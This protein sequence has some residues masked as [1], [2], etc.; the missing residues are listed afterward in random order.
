MVYYEFNPLEPDVNNREEKLTPTT[1]STA[2]HPAKGDYTIRDTECPGLGL[3][4]SPGAKTWIIRKKLR[5]QSYRHTLGHYPAMTLDQARRQARI[6]IGIFTEGRHPT[7]IRESRADETNRQWL[8]N[9]FTVADMWKEWVEQPNKLFADSTRDDFKLVVK[10]LSV[11]PIWHIPFAKLTDET[12]VDAFNRQSVSTDRRATNG[13]RTT[14][15]LIFRY[16]GTAAKHTI[17]KKFKDHRANPIITAMEGKWHETK[18]RTRTVIGKKD[19]LALWWGAVDELRS[20]SESGDGR[21]RS[22]AIIADLLVLLLFWGG[23]KTETLTL[24]WADVNFED[25]FVVFRLPKNGQAHFFPLAPYA[26]TVLRRIQ[27]RQWARK[28]ETEWVFASTRRGNNGGEL[29]HIK[30]PKTSIQKVVEKSGI[31]FSP[32]DMRR[33]FGN[34]IAG[35]D[36]G[37]DT[38]YVKMAM[39]HSVKS[40]VTANHYLI[41]IDRLRPIYEKMEQFALRKSGMVAEAPVELDEEELRQ[42]RE[43]QAC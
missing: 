21:M 34:L 15:N 24:R 26:E 2:P 33:T 42:F 3:R 40:D 5:G 28:L 19:S 4:I 30:E 23:R 14:G 38:L 8:L 12:V 39:N 43:W 13:G 9:Q 25:K 41:K 17:N 22:G 31:S 35:T 27:D 7:L 36:G 32:H 20:E 10:R 29:S 16:L 11:D 1:V 6:D 18:P 37:T